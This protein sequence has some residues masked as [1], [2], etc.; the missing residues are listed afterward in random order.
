MFGFFHVSPASVRLRPCSVPQCALTAD[1]LVIAC[2]TEAGTAAELEATTLIISGQAP[3]S[4]LQPEVPAS[5]PSALPSLPVVVVSEDADNV[6]AEHVRELVSPSG[7]VFDTPDT[8]GAPILAKPRTGMEE[9]RFAFIADAA[10]PGNVKIVPWTEPGTAV[11][12]SQDGR[13]L[14]IEELSPVPEQSFHV[15]PV[16]DDG[17]FHL[18]PLSHPNTVLEIADGGNKEGLAPG[19]L[20]LVLSPESGDPSSSVGF[21]AAKPETPTPKVRPQGKR[22]RDR[23]RIRV[24]ALLVVFGEAFASNPGARSEVMEWVPKSDDLLRLQDTTPIT[25][26]PR[27]LKA[28]HQKFVFQHVPGHTVRCFPATDD[29]ALL[30]A[31]SPT[32]VSF[33]QAEA[34]DSVWEQQFEVVLVD[35][36]DTTNKAFRLMPVAFPDRYLECVADG[37]GQDPHNLATVA[38]QELTAWSE[39]TLELSD[40]C[41]QSVR[42]VNRNK[43]LSRRVR[44]RLDAITQIIGDLSAQAEGGY[45][46]VP[47]SI[48]FVAIALPLPGAGPNV[49]LDFRTL[50]D[51]SRYRFVS[52]DDGLVC[53][54]ATASERDPE[55]TTLALTFDAQAKRITTSRADSTDAKQQFELAVFSSDG[56]GIV[57]ALDLD[58]VVEAPLDSLQSDRSLNLI[59]AGDATTFCAFKLS[60]PRAVDVP[61]V[62]VEAAAVSDEVSARLADVTRTFGPDWRNRKVKLAPA[63]HPNRTFGQMKSGAII[64]SAAFPPIQFTVVDAGL[65]RIALQLPSGRFWSFGEDGASLEMDGDVTA[66]EASFELLLIEGADAGFCLQPCTGDVDDVYVVE[67]DVT[68]PEPHPIRVTTGSTVLAQSAI[69]VVE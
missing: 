56:F 58:L 5:V 9:Q 36:Y 53:I 65:G 46:I 2:D 59:A 28:N 54:I 68:T 3:S 60:A 45:E 47:S 29:K 21:S 37:R 57:P 64:A 15:K 48:D 63:M 30:T 26:K 43:K 23:T 11:H 33:F 34:G 67:I 41:E 7:L 13:M 25:V 42:T 16:G 14:R 39:M 31:E 22:R 40:V 44:A 51:R 18:V 20:H 50:A 10:N 17:R 35:K 6:S 38:R 66:V 19:Q 61:G 55:A 12:V 4:E 69:T 24:D 62:P 52:A 27:S 1:G 32:V 8:A 49:T